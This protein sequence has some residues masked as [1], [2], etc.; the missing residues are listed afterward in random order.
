MAEERRSVLADEARQPAASVVTI[1][2]TIV[3]VSLFIIVSHFDVLCQPKVNLYGKRGSHAFQS[4]TVVD[5]IH[6]GEFG[7]S[8][9]FNRNFP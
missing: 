8:E 6:S 1:T 3:Q 5:P 2:A 4:D 7:Q 9:N